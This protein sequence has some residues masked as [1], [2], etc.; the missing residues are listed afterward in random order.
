MWIF[1]SLLFFI[2]SIICIFDFALA[3]NVLGIGV[4]AVVLLLILGHILI[5]K[6]YCKKAKVF[7]GVLLLE[8]NI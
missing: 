2:T 1:A 5:S 4:P 8:D 7:P 3:G 6:K